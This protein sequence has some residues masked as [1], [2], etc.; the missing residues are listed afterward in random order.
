VSRAKKYISNVL[1]SWAGVVLTVVIGFAFSPYIIRKVG[2]TNFSIWQ[3]A[4][5]LVEYYWLIDFG[6]RSATMKYSAEFQALN[7]RESLSVL[8]STGFLYS[9][10][11]GTVV[12]AGSFALAPYLGQFFHIQQPEFVVLVRVVGLSWS[13]GLVSNVFSA[14]LEGHQR[15]DLTN[16]VWIITMSVRTVG[17]LILLARGGGVQ[18]MGFILLFAQVLGYLCTYRFFRSAVPRVR[19]SYALSS[20]TMMKKMLSYGVHTFTTIISNLLLSRSIPVLIAYFLPIRFLAYWTIPTRI[21]EYT[22]DGFGRIGM[23]TAPN[24]SELMAGGKSKELVDLAVY[25]N[26][27]CFTLFTPMAVFLLTYGFELYSVWIRPEFA[28]DC[29]YLIPVLL[30]G[31][32]IMAGQTNSVSVLFGIGRHKLYSRFLV[33]EA[34]LTVAGLSLVLRPFGLYGAAWVIAILMSLNRGVC[35]CIL[36]SR[37]LGINPLQYAARIYTVP[38]IL[39]AFAWGFMMLLKKHIPGQ[40]V[41]ELALAGTL[42]MLLYTPLAF[43]FC[44]V[45]HHREK[46]L[47]R[48]RRM[49]AIAVA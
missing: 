24:A 16:R 4:L 33:G 2:D 44:L 14:S 19:V 5:S 25:T 21:L 41:P 30:I 27:Y 6:F 26:R 34:I 48:F 40:N 17:I 49:A 36:V 31:E 20:F 47:G 9:S 28:R 39:G 10:L 15:F 38:A 32:T 11:A 13:L 46:L 12:L 22:T 42:M 43:R 3:L 45:P 37:E 1:W 29:A 23:V 7:D 18:Q 8:L 35:L